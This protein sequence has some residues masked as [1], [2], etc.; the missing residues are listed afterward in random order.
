[1]AASGAG[2][3]EVLRVGVAQFAPSVETPGANFDAHIRLAERVADE[4]CDL[5]VFS[6]LSL[7]GYPD[8]EAEVAEVAMWVRDLARLAEAM[9]RGMTR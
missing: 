9:P 5:L 8:S 4:G 3:D 7:S 1:M 6:E 2:S